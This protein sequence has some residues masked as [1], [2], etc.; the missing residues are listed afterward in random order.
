MPKC[1]DHAI[2]QVSCR[3]CFSDE[4]LQQQI[5]FIASVKI[6]A[7]RGQGEKS[8]PRRTDTVKPR[9]AS[10]KDDFFDE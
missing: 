5:D 2:P 7:A 9:K 6:P 10:W 3:K 1:D 4:E 8:R